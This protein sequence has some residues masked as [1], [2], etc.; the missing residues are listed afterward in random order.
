[1]KVRSLLLLSSWNPRRLSGVTWGP[2]IKLWR[3]SQALWCLGGDSCEPPIK[4]WTVPQALWITWG[5]PIKLSRLPQ[6]CTGS[7]TFLK[8][9][10]VDRVFHL[11][12]KARVEYGDPLWHLG[13]LVP[14]HRSNG[15]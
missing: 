7:V 5:P 11:G 2:P 9:L 3:S 6:A 14:P 10:I 8:G 15:D 13:S 12:G 1:V 4:L